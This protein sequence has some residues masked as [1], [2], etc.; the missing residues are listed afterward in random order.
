MYNLCILDDV[1]HVLVSIVFENVSAISTTR[2]P[3]RATSLSRNS[4]ERHWTMTLEVDKIEFKLDII[5]AVARFPIVQSGPP[6]DYLQEIR[7]GFHD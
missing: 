4:W 5:G 6:S 2:C 7:Q 1:Q 3:G